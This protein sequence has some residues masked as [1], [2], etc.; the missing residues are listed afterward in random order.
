MLG[1][2][3]GEI[4]GLGFEGMQGFG[5]AGMLA[6]RPPR[7]VRFTELGARLCQPYLTC[8]GRSGVGSGG[9][10]VSARFT[11][12]GGSGAGSGG[13]GRVVGASDGRG[14]SWIYTNILHYPY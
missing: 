13:S 10:G 9:R 11:I 7:D 6:V 5:F 14:R 8:P 1:L 4:L 2:G 3:F 12:P